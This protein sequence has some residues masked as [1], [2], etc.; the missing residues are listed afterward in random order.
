[1]GALAITGIV[2]AWLV[3]GYIGVALVC[4]AEGYSLGVFG[5]L[6]MFFGP[7]MMPVALGLVLIDWL[8]NLDA[9]GRFDPWGWIN[10]RR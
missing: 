7:F 10:R 9:N 8:A 4:W 5:I 2:V 6:F 3:L 1:M